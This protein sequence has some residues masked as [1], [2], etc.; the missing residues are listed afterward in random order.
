MSEYTLRSIYLPPF[1]AAV[2]A[3]VGTLM[4]AFNDLNGVPTSA[5]PFTLTQVLRTEWKFD[6]FVVSD[7]TAVKELINHGVAANEKEAALRALTAGVD[8]EMV[9][10]LFN[11]NGPALLQ[12]GKLS[13]AV[14]DE[15]VRRK[16]PRLVRGRQAIAPPKNFFPFTS[17]NV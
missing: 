10:R 17:S 16:A 12:E 15:A 3:G 8:M 9:S 5:N 1:K 4:S 6:G 2:D 11:Q 13:Q 14:I 7:Y